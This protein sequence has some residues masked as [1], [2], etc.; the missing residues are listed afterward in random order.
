MNVFLNQIII[1]TDFVF[2]GQ[3]VQ[4]YDKT[5]TRNKVYIYKYSFLSVHK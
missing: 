2:K 3:M 5:K 4:Y 1:I